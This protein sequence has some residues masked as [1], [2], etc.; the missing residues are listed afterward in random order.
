MSSTSFQSI[1]IPGFNVPA[2]NI[3]FIT[4][5]IESTSILPPQCFALTKS[6]IAR[7]EAFSSTSAD[8]ENLTPA[9][10]GFSYI[11][12]TDFW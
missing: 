11:Q 7:I 12:S 5:F 1:S 6:L 9:S 2:D 8:F 3:P 4:L 10:S